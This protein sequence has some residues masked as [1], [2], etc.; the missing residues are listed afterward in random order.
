MPLRSK[1]LVLLAALAARA[2]LAAAQDPPT[3]PVFRADTRLV[4]LHATVLD[5]RGRLVTNLGQSS[6]TVLENGKP[7]PLKQFLREDLPISL[8]LIIDNSGSMRDKRMK[9]AQ[10][11]LELVKASNKQDEVFIVNFNEEAFLDRTFTSDI[12]KMEEALTKI[13]S[14]GGTAM[15]DAV[16][17]SIDYLKEKG[18][19]DKKVLL[20][21]TDG[22]DNTSSAANTME[23]LVEKAQNMEVLIYTI[24]LL[25]E[26]ERAKAK[27]A[28]RALNALAAASGGI[29]YFPKAVDDVAALAVQ[30][31]H[32][33]RNQYTMTYSPVEQALDGTFRRIQV[34]AKGPGK[35]TVRTRSGYYAAPT[36][37]AP[38][39]ARPPESSSLQR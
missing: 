10:A 4:Q 23:K 22:D 17:M 33:I 16:S 20:V 8:G 28:Q 39:P 3:D 11:A 14:R 1:A 29:A 24:G 26:E 15:R 31:A 9:V 13:D 38:K 25:T 35:L 27:R 12:S 34:L 7:Q 6:F 36:A 21:V 19:R 37:P 5:S 18:K 32:E 2:A 30:V